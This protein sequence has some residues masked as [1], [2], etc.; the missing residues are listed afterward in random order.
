[1]QTWVSS[2]HKFRLIIKD[3]QQLQFTSVDQ[4]KFKQVSQEQTE[5]IG[6]VTWTRHFELEVFLLNSL[7]GFGQAPKWLTLS[8]KH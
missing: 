2:V 7:W 1:M 8:S 6:M 5:D 4:M 3:N